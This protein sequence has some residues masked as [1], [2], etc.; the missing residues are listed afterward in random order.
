MI[1]ARRKIFK[2]LAEA[3]RFLLKEPFDST[4]GS[5]VGALLAHNAFA[6]LPRRL[7]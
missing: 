7:D 5:R 6:N 4:V 3:M 2:S 1:P